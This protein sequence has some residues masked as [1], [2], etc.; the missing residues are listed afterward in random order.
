MFCIDIAHSVPH[1]KIS[2]K[3][4]NR[5]TERTIKNTE[6]PGF[7]S[8]HGQMCGLLFSYQI[9]RSLKAKYFFTKKTKSVCLFFPNFFID[10][11]VSETVYKEGKRKSLFLPSSQNY[12]FR[13]LQMLFPTEFIFRVLSF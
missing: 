9:I 5:K 11:F 1:N 3:Q 12:G 10:Q 2:R 13:K 8:L 7:Q 6:P 4:K